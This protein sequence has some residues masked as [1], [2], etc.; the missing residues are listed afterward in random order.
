MRLFSHSSYWYKV[1]NEVFKVLLNESDN[2][3]KQKSSIKAAKLNKKYNKL[4][5]E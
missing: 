4:R 5:N 3:S 1:S 2:M